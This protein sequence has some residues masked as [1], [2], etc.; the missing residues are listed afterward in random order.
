MCSENAVRSRENSN[1]TESTTPMY[2]PRRVC[3]YCASSRKAA[4]NFVQAAD[5]LGRILAREGVGLVYGGGGTGLMGAVA[6][7]ALDEGGHVL[8]I[9]PRFMQEI[10]WGHPGLSELI[11]VE[12]MHERKRLMIENSDAIVAL[13]GGSGT[14]EELAEVITLKRLGMYTC[15]IILVN[16]DG[17][18]DS[19]LAFFDRAVRENFMDD[20]HMTMWSVVLDVEEVLPA[21]RNAPPWGSDARDFAR[22]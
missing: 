17:F 15:P 18:Y 12:T 19:L 9:L 20:R 5:R 6:D 10:E 8:G 7:G 2:R 14:L 4:P 22:L 11:L 13:P 1:V 3:V 16:T 21:I